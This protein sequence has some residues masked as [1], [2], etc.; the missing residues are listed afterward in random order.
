MTDRDTEGVS[1][2]QALT[3]LEQ[4][5]GQLE[6]GDCTLE[7]SLRLFEEGSAL[8]KTCLERLDAA[9]EQIRVLAEDETATDDDLEA[10]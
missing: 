2:E 5:V 6:R 7:E 9:A 10:E 4:I 3:R 1:F 8:R